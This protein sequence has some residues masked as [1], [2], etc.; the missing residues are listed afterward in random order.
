MAGFEQATTVENGEAQ[1][2]PQW[3]VGGRPNGGYLLALLARAAVTAAHPDPLSASA[4]Y[5]SP[6]EPGPANVE[7]ESLRAGRS[8]SQARVRLTQKE[9]VCVEALFTLGDLAVAGSPRW[10]D[11]EPPEVTPREEL[12]RTPIEPPAAGVRI[13]MLELLDQR[14][15]FRRPGDLRGWLS[16]ADDSPFDPLSLLFAVDS[17]P[18]ATFTL[19]GR[20][21]TPTL[22]LTVYVRARPAPGPL[23]VRQRARLLTESLV[24]QVCEVWDST[25]RAVAQATQLAAYRLADA[26]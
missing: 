20:G 23:R 11:A 10:S 17:F 5:L 25:G 2:D 13:D 16:F 8:A 24:D 6:P 12:P 19:G 1:L 9:R 4:V 18:P 26:G 7:V 22:E 15:D 21:W 3:T 14:V